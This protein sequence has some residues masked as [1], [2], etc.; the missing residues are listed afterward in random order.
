LSAVGGEQLA[1]RLEGVKYHYQQASLP[2]FAASEASGYN[3]GEALLYALV[4]LLLGEQLLAWSA[5]YHPAAREGT[6]RFLR[7]AAAR[8]VAAVPTGSAAAAQ[9]G[10]TRQGGAV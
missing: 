1:A 7:P 2:Q 8:S 4:L 6:A 5:S 3:L 9:T 10:A